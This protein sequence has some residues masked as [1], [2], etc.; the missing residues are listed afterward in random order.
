M[1]KLSTAADTVGAGA[2]T[3]AASVMMTERILSATKVATN[4]DRVLAWRVSVELIVKRVSQ[5]STRVWLVIPTVSDARETR[6][7]LRRA[8][9][10]P[11]VDAMPAILQTMEV[12][13][14]CVSQ[15]S[16]KTRQEVGVVTPSR[17]T[18]T[19]LS[20]TLRSQTPTE[21]TEPLILA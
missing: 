13:A 10:R 3:G 20:E 8:Q 11:T 12:H 4:Q 16:G 2:R 21:V 6:A 5:A 14:R 19:Q 18:Q 9:L 15:E 17:Q 7:H 1:I